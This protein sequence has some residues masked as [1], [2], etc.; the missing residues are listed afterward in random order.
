MGTSILINW[1]YYGPEVI[2]ELLCS[3]QLS[4][5]F[6]LLINIKMPNLSIFGILIFMRRK[7]SILGLY[8]PDTAVFLDISKLPSI[9]NFVLS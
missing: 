2:K 8:E 5:K 7:H 4:M 3:S 9:Q 1:M 6:F